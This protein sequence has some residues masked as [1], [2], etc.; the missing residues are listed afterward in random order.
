MKAESV[1]QLLLLGILVGLA[2]AIYAMIE[3]VVPALQHSCTI[4]SYF[5]C[6]KIDSSGHT[7]TLGVQD[8]V[9]GIAG[10]IAL[11]VVDI[12][13][14]RTW[15]REWLE[16]VTV[17]S[18]LGVLLSIYFAYLELVVIQGVCPICL[19]AYLSNVLVFGCAAY[20]MRLG[21]AERRAGRGTV[22]AKPDVGA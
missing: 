16:V 5:S 22:E 6:G 11:F 18:G 8:Y 19:G 13:L 3:S 21:S 4:N 10:F 9:W 12:P 14:Y 2:F 7:T 20:L 17:L 15:K 1:H